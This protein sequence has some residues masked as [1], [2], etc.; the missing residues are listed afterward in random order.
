[1]CHENTVVSAF[2]CMLFDRTTFD[3]EVVTRA[4]GSVHSFNPPLHKQ[5]DRGVLRSEAR[6][7]TV[8]GSHAGTQLQRE[9]QSHSADAI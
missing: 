4:F 7:G 1:M 8:Q 9:P 5:V 6:D 3:W 2:R